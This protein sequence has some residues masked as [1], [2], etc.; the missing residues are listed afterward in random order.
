MFF[1]NVHSV[2]YMKGM[3]AVILKN[4]RDSQIRQSKKI[5]NSLGYL[6]KKSGFAMYCLAMYQNKN[7]FDQQN[8][9]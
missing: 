6:R 3:N 1:V 4:P 5:S 8:I 7:I 9:A 2:W